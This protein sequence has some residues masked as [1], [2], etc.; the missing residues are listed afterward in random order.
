M[1]SSPKKREGTLRFES[2]V[3]EVVEDFGQKIECR[4]A[5]IAKFSKKLPFLSAINGNWLGEMY[6]WMLH[7]GNKTRRKGEFRPGLPMSQRNA[8]NTMVVLV[9]ALVNMDYVRRGKTGR[10]VPARSP[11]QIFIPRI[12]AYMR[13]RFPGGD[14]TLWSP[15]SHRNYT[16]AFRKMAEFLH[17]GRKEWSK[18]KME[19]LRQR[20]PFIQ[21]DYEDLDIN[22]PEVAMAFCEWLWRQENPQV[23]VDSMILFLGQHLAMR[24]AEV[25]D[26]PASLNDADR[27]TFKVDFRTKRTWIRG[28]GRGGKGKKQEGPPLAEYVER[29]L[30]EYRE[31][32]REFL[33]SRGISDRDL[34]YLVFTKSPQLTI[35]EGREVWTRM[36]AKSGRLNVRLKLYATRYNER[37]GPADS[38]NHFIPGLAKTHSLGR[39]VYGTFWARRIH[40]K[41][42][43]RYMRISD[44]KGEG[45]AVVRKYINFDRSAEA[46]EYTRLASYGSPS[47][48][49]HAHAEV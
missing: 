14:M 34:P 42:L 33:V 44:R 23:K 27:F 22:P 7:Y 20:L 32:R 13:E 1:V 9:R 12:E 38:E 2:F 26:A 24:Y 11:S 40:P 6:E 46:A 30:I 16:A 8:K 5:R 10:L 41:T 37:P 29:R 25:V 43:I 36:S 18:A 35:K 17:Y 19:S 28:K 47:G 39:H 3:S 4:P 15:S 48:S 45:W 31:W 21:S 49:E